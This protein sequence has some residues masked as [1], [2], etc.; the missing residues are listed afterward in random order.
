MKRTLRPL[1]GPDANGDLVE[2][3]APAL[4]DVDIAAERGRDRRREVAAGELLGALVE[5]EVSIGDVDRLVRHL[6]I[7]TLRGGRQ[8]Y[9]GVYS[10]LR[11]RCNRE[12][13]RRVSL[14]VGWP[15]P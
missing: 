7:V 10:Y 5:R 12:M 14:T 4:L 15:Q 11:P 8:L 13:E 9:V 6:C 3:L 1:A 2:P